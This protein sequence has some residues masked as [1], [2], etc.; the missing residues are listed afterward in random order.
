MTLVLPSETLQQACLFLYYQ[1][2]VLLTK[3][4]QLSSP[5]AIFNNRMRSKTFVLTRW[6]CENVLAVHMPKLCEY[7]IKN[8]LTHQKKCF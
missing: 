6:H 5:W 3:D 8:S 4:H 1:E 2:E 7:E